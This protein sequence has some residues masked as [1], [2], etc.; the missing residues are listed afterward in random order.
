MTTFTIASF[1]VKNLIGANAEYY[2][3]EQYT[4][5]EHAWKESWLADQIISLN[6]DIVC[7]Q[8]I[9]DQPSLDATIQEANTRGELLNEEVI[10]NKSKKYHRRA[11]FKKLGFDAYDANSLFFAPNIHD[12]EAGHRRPGL[13]ILSRNGFEGTPE[14]IQKLD[15]PLVIKLP[16]LGGGDAGQFTLTRL[17]RPIIKAR[18]RVGDTVVTV[19]N[20]HFKS[21]LGEYLKPAG[22]THSPEADLLNYDPTGRALGSLRA[23]LRRM[24]EALILRQLIVA[25]LRAGNPVMSL[26]DFNDGEHAVSSEIVTGEAPFK[27]YSWMRRHD[28]QRKNDRYSDDENTQI[29]GDIEAMKMVSAEKLFVRKSLRDMVYTSAFGGVYESIDQILMSR[30]FHP[31]NPSAIGTMDYFSVFNDHLTDGSHPEAPYNKLASDHGQIMAHMRL[32]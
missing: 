21:K 3:F 28:A 30:H 17:S 16:E 10:P 4:E 7:F 24:A 29:R 27:N 22:A 2:R 11:I 13:A 15:T 12:G 19:F 6:A 26:G 32:F 5:E 23:G 31:D 8:E 20:C 14:V 9:F 25:E 18:I 1:N